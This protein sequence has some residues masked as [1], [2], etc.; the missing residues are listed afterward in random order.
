MAIEEGINA[1]LIF[2]AAFEMNQ[3]NDIVGVVQV[4]KQVC[5]D[6]KILVALGAKMNADDASFIKKSGANFVVM[7][8]ECFNSSKLEYLLSQYVKPDYIPVKSSDFTVGQKLDF[9]LFHMMPL[10][11]KY[12]PLL[13]AG[14][15]LTASKRQKMDEVTEIYIRKAD[16]DAFQKYIDQLEDKSAAAL[17]RRCR[18]KYLG[19]SLAFQNL[20]LLL[21]DQSE[22]SSFAEGKKLYESCEGLAAD[23]LTNLASLPDPWSIVNQSADSAFGSIE[24]SVSIASYSGVVSLVSGIGDPKICMLGA[25]L[26]NIGM[27]ELDPKTTQKIRKQAFEKMHAEEKN[28]FEKHPIFS[29]NMILARKLPLPDILKETILASHERPDQKGFPNRLKAAKIPAESYII[30]ICEKIDQKSAIRMGQ[31]RRTIKDVRN[32]VLAEISDDGQQVPIPI[33]QKVRD[34]LT[35]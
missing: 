14:Q 33:V 9:P 34:I 28:E 20:L 13:M 2:I 19:L 12:M 22:Y 30:Q 5:P 10:N 25:L 6:S 1:H 31:V 16:L 23:L 4:A 8:N 32:E 29:L 35:S 26:C 7:E 11:R 27:I 17:P 18:A 21:S 24:R 15:E 3:K